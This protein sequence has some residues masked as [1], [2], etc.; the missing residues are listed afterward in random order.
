MSCIPKAKN[1]AEELVGQ[2]KEK[3]GEATGNE[4]SGRCF[5]A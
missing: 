4:L 3:T 5:R 1:E 2:G